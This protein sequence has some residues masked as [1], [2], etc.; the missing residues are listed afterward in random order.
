MDC[1]SVLFFGEFSP[2]SYLILEQAINTLGIF[3]KNLDEIANS[4]SEK[5]LIRQILDEVYL[6]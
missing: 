1:T 2:I 3:A 4:I 6:L 5:Y